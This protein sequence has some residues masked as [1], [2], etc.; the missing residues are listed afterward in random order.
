MARR[1]SSRLWEK[2]KTWINR[3]HGSVSVLF[4]IREGE[5]QHSKKL[6]QTS[7]NVVRSRYEERCGCVVNAHL[8]PI[9]RKKIAWFG[10][11]LLKICAKRPENHSNQEGNWGSKDARSFSLRWK[12]DL[13][14]E[15]QRSAHATNPWPWDALRV[16]G[17]RSGQ[18]GMHVDCVWKSLRAGRGE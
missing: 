3:Q 5:E 1:N 8:H 16:H 13:K 10:P 18:P 6:T 12:W 4:Y 9:S 7:G 11:L 14:A 15:S 2:K 17:W